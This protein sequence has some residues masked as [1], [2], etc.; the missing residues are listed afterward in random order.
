MATSPPAPRPASARPS[1]RRAARPQSPPL[2]TRRCSVKRSRSRPRSARPLPPLALLPTPLSGG[3]GTFA[4]PTPGAGSHPVPAAYNGEGNFPPSPSASFSQT[5]NKASSSTAVTASANPAVFGQAFTFT[6]TVSAV[7]P[8]VGTPTGTVTF[9]VDGV[10]QPNVTLRNCQA[11]LSSSTLRVGS[12]TA[13]APYNA[14]RNSP[15]PTPPTP[16]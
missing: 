14:N 15:P 3:Q 8:G 6:A 10:A 7:S 16:P 4:R 12:H 11:T 13:T 5:V 9:T 2:P 1:T